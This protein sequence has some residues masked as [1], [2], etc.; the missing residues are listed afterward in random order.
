M[1][2]EKTG[3]GTVDLGALLGGL[4]GGNAGKNDV[5]KDGGGKSDAGGGISADAI[6]A[7]LNDPQM[8]AK[9]PEVMAMLKPMMAGMSGGT[10]VSGASSSGSKEA[11]AEA[12]VEASTKPVREDGDGEAKAVVASPSKCAHDRRLA[13]LKALR[14]Y[15]CPRRQEAIDY[16][17]R[18]DRFGNMFRN[19]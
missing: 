15:M 9:L 5:G 18:M 17:L 12:S 3:G 16:I 7:V 2:E 8:M 1:S 19:Q 10:A 6:G 14:P 11:S 13:L 4:L